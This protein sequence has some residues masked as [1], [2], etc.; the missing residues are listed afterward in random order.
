MADKKR[1]TRYR[2]TAPRSGKQRSVRSA[3]RSPENE[4]QQTAR[5][6]TA[7]ELAPWIAAALSALA[8]I[9]GLWTAWETRRGA[10]VAREAA[11]LETRA[12]LVRSCDVFSPAHFRDGDDMM[13]LDGTHGNDLDYE[14][15]I[16]RSDFDNFRSKKAKA[17]LRCDFTNYSRVPILT[18]TVYMAVDY[19]HHRLK[20]IEHNFPFSALGPGQSR[21]LWIVN[22]SQEPLTVD[23]PHRTRYARFPE[24]STFQDQRFLPALSDYWVLQRDKD[25]VENLD[26]SLM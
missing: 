7:V 3:E 17:Y 10:E 25:P 14:S 12:A 6:K 19:H 5:E 1:R 18:V 11:A 16:E 9:G 23:T 24:L 26:Q 21:A 15:T 4:P 8:A 22:E 20:K 2:Q 13:M